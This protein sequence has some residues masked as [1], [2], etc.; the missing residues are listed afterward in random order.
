M[1]PNIFKFE[2]DND[3]II[4]VGKITENKQYTLSLI[5]CELE[6]AIKQLVN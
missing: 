4:D 2:P 6:R 1:R 3:N 5:N